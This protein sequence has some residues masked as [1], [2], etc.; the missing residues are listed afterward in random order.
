MSV[1]SLRDQPFAVR[2]GTYLGL[3]ALPLLAAVEGLTTATDD[4]GETESESVAVDDGE[5]EDETSPAVPLVPS[6][7][8]F[9][10]SPSFRQLVGWDA[11][12]V[13]VSTV[14]VFPPPCT[15]ERLPAKYWLVADPASTAA[16]PS[17]IWSPQV[18][19]AEAGDPGV[20]GP[21]RLAT[22]NRLAWPAHA[23]EVAC[24]AAIS[25][26]VRFSHPAGGWAVP[27]PGGGEV[28][29]A[30]LMTY[31]VSRSPAFSSYV[32]LVLAALGVVL[33]GWLLRK[34]WNIAR[35][36]P[37]AES[38]TVSSVKEDLPLIGAITTAAGS[39]FAA[40][41]LVAD[42]VP[43]FRASGLVGVSLLAAALVALGAALQAG[44]TGSANVGTF[45]G[46]W[47]SALT[48]LA[49]P[50]LLLH[51]TFDNTAVR[52]IISLAA[53]VLLVVAIAFGPRVA[54]AVVTTP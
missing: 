37:M 1:R 11:S 51:G 48:A 43:G 7:L 5:S 16:A 49:V 17:D 50:F 12:E 31:V 33:L 10:M 46:L 14:A 25:G 29:D 21:P 24:P 47:G 34:M 32:G 52:V 2:I 44:G 39:L 22:V 45:I 8:A 40:T 4:V 18:T 35:K 26:T 53:P 6:A 54:P 19:S 28:K 23:D 15:R 3:L 9:E 13:A 36:T 30:A 20:G 42:F 41:A 27:V 38:G